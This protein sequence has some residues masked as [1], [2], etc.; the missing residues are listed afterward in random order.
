MHLLNIFVWWKP[1]GT[2]KEVLARAGGGPPG[3]WTYTL[4]TR[5]GH[6]YCPGRDLLGGVCGCG[7]GWC[8]DGGVRERDVRYKAKKAWGWDMQTRAQGLGDT[9]VN[10][11]GLSA[12]IG[13]YPAPYI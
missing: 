12:P 3:L 11:R 9:A 4:G 1:G 2:H 5:Q 13:V 6:E 10:I 7:R 8:V